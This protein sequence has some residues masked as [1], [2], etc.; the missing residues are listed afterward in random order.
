MSVQ[1][2]MQNAELIPGTLNNLVPMIGAMADCGISQYVAK[3]VAE[4][5][6]AYTGNSA[7]TGMVEQMVQRVYAALPQPVPEQVAP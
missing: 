2:G 7:L 1:N 3:D 4:K 5:V 6:L